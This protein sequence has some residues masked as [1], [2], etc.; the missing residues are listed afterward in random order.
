MNLAFS[1]WQQADII[2]HSLRLAKSYQYWTGETLCSSATTPAEIAHALFHASFALLSHGTEADPILNYG[3]QQTL[4]LWEIVWQDLIQMP[5][6]LTAELSER[7]D[8]A[9]LLNQATRQGYL[10]NYQGIRISQTGRRFRIENA[11]IWD[12]LDEQG[13][14]CGQAAK[15]SQ[16]QWLTPKD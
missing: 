10:Q 3:N 16:W 15:F 12:V 8:R 9:E 1:P 13:Q 6:R 14:R 11:E 5:S 2:R 7:S 4:M